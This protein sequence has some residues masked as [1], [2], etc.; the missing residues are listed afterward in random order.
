MMVMTFDPCTLPMA[1]RTTGEMVSARSSF[2]T[3]VTSLTMFDSIDMVRSHP[4]RDP[5]QTARNHP[6]KKR[7]M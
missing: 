1:G 2:R 3:F 6:E 5:S 7:Q 4:S